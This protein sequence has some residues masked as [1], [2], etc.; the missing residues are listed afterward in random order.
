M[1]LTVLVVLV[2]ALALFFEFANA[3]DDAPERDGRP[4]RDAG[5]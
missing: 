2:A 3:F 1:D 5:A 4:H